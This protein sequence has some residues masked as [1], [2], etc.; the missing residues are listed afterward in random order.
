MGILGRS[1][2][3][4]LFLSALLGTT[5]FTF[6]LFLQRVR[7]LFSLLVRSS[8]EAKTVG[9]LFLLVFP[10]AL[11]F[12][13]PIGVLVAV[14][15][16]LSRKSSDNEIVGM[17]A[18]GIPSRVLAWP[19][20]WFATFVM[21]I[22]AL[23]T[24]WLNPWSIRETYRIINRLATEQV[25]SEIPERV[26]DESFPNIVLYVGEVIPGP[27]PRWKQVLVG[28]KTPPDKRK[29][30]QE[31]ADMPRI[32]VAKE[33]LVLADPINQRVQLS[34]TEGRTIEIAANGDYN[35][36]TFQQADQILWAQRPDEQRSRPFRN[37]D[38]GPLWREAKKS[39]DARIEFHQR[40]ALP[41]ACI[42]LAMC[43]LPLGIASR[44]G[45]KS[46]AVVLT[47]M[48]ALGYYSTL[49]SLIGLAK[50]GRLPVEVAVWTPDVILLV[51]GIFGLARLEKVGDRDLFS[52]FRPLL[53]SISERFKSWLP[54]RESWELPSLGNIVDN[55]VLQTFLFYFLVLLSS[56]ILITH[57]F[58]FFELLGDI[59]RNKIPMIDVIKYHFYLTP[60][61]IY[62]A[63]PVSVLVAVLV[64][65]GVMAKQNEVTALKACG[66]SLY[67]LSVPVLLAALTLS[68]ALF[69]FDTTI[70]PAA[71]REQ[72]ALRNKIKGRPIQTYLNLGRNWIRGEGC[73][74]FYYKYLDAQQGVMTNVNVYDQDCK[75]S[76]I[77][78]HTYADRARWEPGVKTWVFQNGWQRTLGQRG[79]DEKYDFAGK[80]ATFP[81]IVEPPQYFLREVKQEKQMTYEELAQFIVDLQKAGFDT[82][83]LQVQYYKKFAVPLFAF[84]MALIAVPFAFAGGNRGAMSGVGISLSVAIAYWSISQLFEQVGVL[85]Q[86]SPLVAAWA[87]DVLFSLAGLY[88]LSRIRS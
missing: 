71:N 1:V 56:F 43:G 42:L 78:R 48:I 80:T 57:V 88:F 70:V 40:L 3:G 84:I 61:L 25:S 54:N 79:T 45:G 31:P 14:L 17:R 58:T 23:M 37:M 28:D 26:F 8:A 86:L 50:E 38:M 21:I 77:R 52:Y 69:A 76:Q 39:R 34:M 49:I 51:I 36:T 32:T 75:D 2:L 46:G 12:T 33:A 47:V 63:A 82:V 62:D 19:V 53:G 4:Q 55:Y 9:Y 16:V 20:L 64:T 60:K 15:L 7:D 30:S 87:P 5:L 10:Y 22:A 13:L 74:T 27:I 11:S 85:N 68:A 41:I 44:K 72:D 67:R 24:T 35:V 18:S 83:R 66:I 59:V 65:F 73:R 6:V 81:D 29:S